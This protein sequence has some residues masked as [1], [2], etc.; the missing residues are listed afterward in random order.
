[1]C[2]N[3]YTQMLTAVAY[4]DSNYIYAVSTVYKRTFL[5]SFI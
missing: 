1:M 2:I 5:W 3:L 4:S